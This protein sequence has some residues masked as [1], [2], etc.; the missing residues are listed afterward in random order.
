MIETQYVPNRTM[1]IRG[2]LGCSA[3]DGRNQSYV[4]FLWW[5]LSAEFLFQ[6]IGSLTSNA[7]SS[8]VAGTGLFLLIYSLVALRTASQLCDSEKE[9]LSSLPYS[10]YPN[11]TYDVKD[12]VLDGVSLTV[13]TFKL[14][15]LSYEIPL[16]LCIILLFHQSLVLLVC[17]QTD[18]RKYGWKR[19]S[20]DGI[21]WGMHCAK[22]KKEIK[23]GCGGFPTGGFL[24]LKK[25]IPFS[26]GLT[27]KVFHFW[28][29]IF[30]PQWI[31]QKHHSIWISFDLRYRYLILS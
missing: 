14:K 2:K 26:V 21:I 19:P 27:L 15:L 23:K 9:H 22:S 28:T 7:V 4:P 13:S 17:L 25:K 30:L 20:A 1:Q 6:A 10:R 12:C 24:K 18:R 31:S 8:V 5:D 3:V 16:S 11:P 29:G